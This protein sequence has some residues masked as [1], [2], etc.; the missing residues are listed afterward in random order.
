MHTLSKINKSKEEEGGEGKR[1]G[2]GGEG[3]EDSLQ[4]PTMVDPGK[5]ESPWPQVAQIGS[6]MI[7]CG[8]DLFKDE[9]ISWMLDP[10]LTP[11]IRPDFALG[12]QP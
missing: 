8:L 12:S 6:D 10:Y 9:S 7:K 1:N 11:N 4:M 3:E 2:E 5:V